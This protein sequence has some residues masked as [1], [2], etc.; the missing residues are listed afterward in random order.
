MF[1]QRPVFPLNL[2]TRKL[3]SDRQDDCWRK[4]TPNI[5]RDGSRCIIIR[6][7]VRSLVLGIRYN[8]YNWHCSEFGNKK[9]K[10]AILADVAEYCVLNRHFRTF[11]LG[12]EINS[13]NDILFEIYS[14]IDKSICSADYSSNF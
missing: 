12:R 5:V 1:I 13:R 4:V 6:T 3:Y 8:E 7:I 2:Y 14:N 11:L 10:E 9:E